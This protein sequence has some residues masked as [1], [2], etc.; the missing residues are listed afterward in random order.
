MITL[1]NSCTENS[2]PA[3]GGRMAGAL[4]LCPLP[5]LG[6][7]LRAKP[8]ARAEPCS[9]PGHGALCCS[10]AR[11]TR[12]MMSRAPATFTSQRKHVQRPWGMFLDSLQAQK[13]GELLFP[14]QAQT[15]AAA[16]PL[17]AG[18]C[19]PEYGYRAD[20]VARAGPV[21]KT[22]GLKCR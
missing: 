22:W 20:G 12:W 9:Q 18:C 19:W 21:C 13:E 4:W 2:A 17:R 16:F 14:L 5:V 1:C 11:A 3:E 10:A 8:Q 6:V 7:S 15:W